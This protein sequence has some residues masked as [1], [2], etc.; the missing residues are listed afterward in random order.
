MGGLT[1]IP[2]HR[3][4]SAKLWK[5]TEVPVIPAKDRPLERESFVQEVYAKEVECDATK[6]ARRDALP[7][8]V[9]ANGTGRS[10]WLF[11]DY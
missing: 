10:T 1:R 9:G 5:S 4:T 7:L 2:M 3:T 8:W 11:S 6:K